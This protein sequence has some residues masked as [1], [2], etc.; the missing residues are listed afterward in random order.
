[1]DPAF[2]HAEQRGGGLDV[3]K[4]VHVSPR[5]SPWGFARDRRMCDRRRSDG[6]LDE[7][8]LL[9]ARRVIDAIG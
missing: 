9:R 3:A 5:R 4:F 1:V 8:A 7:L 6:A 2:G